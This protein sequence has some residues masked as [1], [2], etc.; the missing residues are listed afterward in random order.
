MEAQG[1]VINNDLYWGLG[2]LLLAWLILC[3]P[4]LDFWLD[5]G[6]IQITIELLHDNPIYERN[7]VGCGI[8]LFR[9]WGCKFRLYSI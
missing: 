5:L 2:I 4:I 3:R 1:P 8:V 9:R 7:H 6:F